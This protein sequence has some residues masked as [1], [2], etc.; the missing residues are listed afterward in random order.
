[1]RDNVMGYSMFARMTVRIR[2]IFL[3]CKLAG[4]FQFKLKRL[5][6]EAQETRYRVS[7]ALCRVYVREFF[8]AVQ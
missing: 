5:R 6:I 1:M 3:W 7:G 2:Q 4:P 8:G